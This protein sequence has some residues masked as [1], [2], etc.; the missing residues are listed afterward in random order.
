M[1]TPNGNNASSCSTRSPRYYKIKLSI[2]S[3]AETAAGRVESVSAHTHT[4]KLSQHYTNMSWKPV[5]P[6]PSSPQLNYNTGRKCKHNQA[7]WV[8][9]DGEWSSIRKLHRQ[10]WYIESADSITC[11]LCT[12]TWARVPVAI[13]QLCA[14]LH[15]PSAIRWYGG[16]Q[17]PNHKGG[18]PWQPVT[19]TWFWQT[20]DNGYTIRMWHGPSEG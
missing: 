12:C 11:P 7:R 10:V 15:L 16:Q 4:H 1:Q 17:K 9:L 6:Y 18:N 3:A 20:L 13:S 19:T 5:G 8:S 2:S 14:C